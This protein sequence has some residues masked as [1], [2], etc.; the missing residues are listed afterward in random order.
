[1]D[2]RVE[3]VVH[4]DVQGVGFRDFVR[5]RASQR[6]LRGTVR[7]RADGAVE[8]VAEGPQDDVEALLAD[9]REGPRMARVEQVEVERREAGG[10][11]DGFRITY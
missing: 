1:M 8:V 6:G 3:A 10:S 5:R 11:L 9:L 4:G 7:N 2:A